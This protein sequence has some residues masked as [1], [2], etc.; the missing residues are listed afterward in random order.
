MI[1]VRVKINSMSPELRSSFVLEFPPEDTVE[2][3]RQAIHCILKKGIIP[4]PAQKSYYN[5]YF[6]AT[7]E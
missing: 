1:F 6:D 7:E 4:E 3:A 5:H 2:K